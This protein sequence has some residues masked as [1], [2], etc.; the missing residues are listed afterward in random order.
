[1]EAVKARERRGSM[2]E[3]CTTS[4][5]RDGGDEKAATSNYGN[6]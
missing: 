1:M 5:E 3:R 6:R 2:F 4:V